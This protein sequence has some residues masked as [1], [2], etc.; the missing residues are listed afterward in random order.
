[1]GIERW[2]GALSQLA[3]QN[4]EMFMPMLDNPDPDFIARQL[5]ELYGAPAEALRQQEEVDALR[6][7]RAEQAAEAQQA[8]LVQQQGEALKS[9]GEGA[10]A[11]SAVDPET[12][13]SVAGG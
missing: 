11:A 5:A 3:A 7:E 12:L 4:P 13:R 2:L 10:Q 9:M 1:M 6:R 8:A